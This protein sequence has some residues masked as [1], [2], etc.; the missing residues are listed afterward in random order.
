MT[1]PAKADKPK[2]W[3][4]GCKEAVGDRYLMCR[5]HWD[6][7]PDRLKREYYRALHKRARSDAYIPFYEQTV[8]KIRQA[9][10][11]IEGTGRHE[12]AE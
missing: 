12:G 7:V 6:K 3:A 4:T 1:K 2:C 5:A 10:E 8:L 11:R 9:L